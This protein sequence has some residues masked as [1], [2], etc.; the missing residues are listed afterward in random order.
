MGHRYCL[1]KKIKCSFLNPPIFHF[2]LEYCTDFFSAFFKNGKKVQEWYLA[3][4]REKAIKWI[5]FL[6]VKRRK[7]HLFADENS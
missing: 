1:L 4:K 7:I 5:R 6:C 3:V 2:R